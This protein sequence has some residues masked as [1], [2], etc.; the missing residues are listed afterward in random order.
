VLA[1]RPDLA[2]SL[3]LVARELN[4]PRDLTTTLHTIV[5]VAARSL[6]GID[7]AGI[8]LGHSPG[9]METMAAT[10]EF[11]WK[12]DRLQHEVGEGP[13]V[14]AIEGKQLVLVENAKDDSRWP[15]YVKPAVAM[16]L[17][18]QLGIR[19]C[20]DEQILGGLNLYSSSTDAVDPDVVHL[21]E[22]F[23]EHAALALGRAQREDQLQVAITTRQLIGQATGIIMERHALDEARAF[24]HLIR[25]SSHSNVKLREVARELVDEV[26]GRADPHAEA[27]SHGG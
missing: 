4:A 26:N 5:E 17:R 25:V 9:E 16:G 27:L 8:T 6:P 14:H 7:H 20:A 10:D 19:L 24:D 3:V 11:A 23:A 1:L 2:D 12:L 22:L 18:S 15:R 21:A 13:L